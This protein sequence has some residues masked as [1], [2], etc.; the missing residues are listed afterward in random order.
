M[1]LEPED[2]KDAFTTISMYPEVELIGGKRVP[3]DFRS[4]KN[5]LENFLERMMAVVP[6]K[7]QE[8]TRDNFQI[9]M[10]R[11]FVRQKNIGFENPLVM[12]E[13][14]EQLDKNISVT[15]FYYITYGHSNKFGV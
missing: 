10:I 14:L 15:S 12:M 4:L 1:G 13:T 7:T 3:P 5:E 9:R 6:F 2:L 8:E 11:F